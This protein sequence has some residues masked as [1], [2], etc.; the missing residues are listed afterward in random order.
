MRSYGQFCSVAK[1]LDVIGD[2]WTLLIVREL[3]LAGSARYTDLRNGLP[4]I[5]TNLL[6][7]R[8]RE[9]E[10]HGVLRREE[11]PPP[12]ATTVFRLTPRGEALRPLL[13]ELFRWGMPLMAEGPAA[14]DRFR[15]QWMTW[16]AESCLVDRDP[17]G[18][19][20]AVEL[21]AAEHPLVVEAAGGKVRVRRGSAEH[22]DA[23][24]TGDPYPMLGLLSGVIDLEAARAM[25]VELEGDPAVVARLL[26][27]GPALEWP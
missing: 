17:E 3:L 23:V 18:P 26:P 14:G 1:A 7:E 5:A 11:A 20:V 25:G 12:V 22:T 13:E 9:L 10:S 21:R 6:A 4:G 16:S 27:A 24:L 2:R 19:A 15:E 8:L